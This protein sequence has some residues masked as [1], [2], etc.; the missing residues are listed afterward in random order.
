MKQV[1]GKRQVDVL[2]LIFG[3][4]LFTLHPSITAG[5]SGEISAAA[6]SLGI[7]HPSGYPFYVIIAKLFTLALP[8]G[9]IAYRVNMV[10]AIFGALTCMMVYMI[11]KRI[12][13]EAGKGIDVR[14]KESS[15]SL[16]LPV[17]SSLPAFFA[18]FSLALSYQFW[19][20]STVAEVY[21]LNAFLMLLIIY[22]LLVWRDRG[23]SGQWSSDSRTLYLV[24]FLLGL[25]IGNHHTIV[26]VVPGALLFVLLTGRGFSSPLPLPAFAFAVAFLLLGLSVYLYL[27]TRSAQNPFMDWGDPQTT[28]NFFDVFTRKTFLP[29]KIGRDWGMFITQFKSFNPISEFTIFGLFFGLTG[30]W[31]V[32]KID[33]RT[34]VMLLTIAILTSYG[35]IVLAGSSKAD[36]GLFRKFYLPSHAVFS[37][38]MGVGA[39][40]GLKLLEGGKFSTSRPLNLSTSIVFILAAASLIWQFSAHYPWIRNSGNY[41]AYDYG[42]NELNSLRYGAA[43]ISKGEIKTFPLWYLQGV[44]GY[45]EDVNVV[46]AYFLTQRWYLREV[47]KVAG[48]PREIRQDQ[49]Y[50]QMLID[51]IY[52]RNADKGVYTGFLDEEYLPTNLL[53]YTQGITFQLY[54]KPEERSAGDVWPIYRLRGVERVEEWMGRGMVDILKDYAS[55]H[56]NTGLEYY[57]EGDIDRAITEF[58][59]ALAINPDEPDSLHNLAAL[60]AK[61]G[62]KLKEAEGLAKKVLGLYTEEKDREMARETIK[63]IEKK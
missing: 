24:A 29:E 23:I 14:D 61:K 31:G 22:I 53:T 19:Y 5:D 17:S 55:S 41:L 46:T 39:A 12:L 50:K 32:C 45:R 40:T 33:K 1:E 28:Q 3:L 34:A 51:A 49:T 16:P 54:K 27:P 25:G 4:F 62:I 42:M 37:I 30:I 57:N 6:F 63:E 21:T 36:T 58:E 60:Y 18:A 8:F 43:Y 7:P 13:Q 44:E 9:N 52:K 2:I 35:L 56:Y 20:R 26:L 10:S 15:L 59:K 48:V 11:T 38:F 47:L